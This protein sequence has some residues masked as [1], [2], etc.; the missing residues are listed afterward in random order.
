MNMQASLLCL[1]MLDVEAALAFANTLV[2]SRTS[3]YLNTLQGHIFRGAWANQTYEEIAQASRYSSTHLKKVGST[4]WELL[5]LGLGEEVSKKNFRA[6]LERC[7]RSESNSVSLDGLAANRLGADDLKT[8]LLDTS[9]LGKIALFGSTVPSPKMQLTQPD[10]ELPFPEGPVELGSRFYINHPSIEF[11]CNHAISRPGRLISI[12]APH[13]MGKTSFLLRILHSAR[14][15]NYRTVMLNL[16]LVDSKMLY[17]PDRFLQ[18]FCARVTHELRLP[19][20]LSDYWNEVFGSKTSCKDYFENYLLPQLDQPLVLALDEMDVVFPYPEIVNYLFA[21][22]RAWTEAAKT[23]EVWQKLRL[24]LVH[25]TD[26]Y[27]PLCSYPSLFN[28]G[29]PI[30]MPEFN[31]T[32]VEALAQQHGLD[33]STTQTQLL[34]NLIGGHPYLVRMALYQMVCNSMSLEQFLQVAPTEMGPYSRH[35]Q[36]HLLVLEQ[37]PELMNA[38]KPVL[39]SSEPVYHLSPEI[40]QLSQMGLIHLKDSQITLCCDLYRQYLRS[41][42]MT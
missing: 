7:H 29:L 1:S 16:Q 9:L 42:L 22:L 37:Q 21:L 40:T 19:L 27:S 25:S 5:S 17:D 4:L 11:C 2:F 28:L 23:S 6:A 38:L 32:Q 41:R 30:V 20:R 3:R 34:M 18:W 31:Q 33:W 13:Q 14:Q 15:Q 26:L 8:D 35:L 39:I 10:E 24:V 36:H 12:K